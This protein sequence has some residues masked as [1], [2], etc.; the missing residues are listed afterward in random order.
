M[1]NDAGTDANADDAGADG[2]I[3]AVAVTHLCDTQADCLSS[4]DPTAYVC[5]D[6]GEGRRCWPSCH[7]GECGGHV[8]GNV[9]QTSLGLCGCRSAADCSVPALAPFCAPIGV[10]GDCEMEADCSGST[11][12]CDPDFGICVEC[13]LDA[14][15][16]GGACDLNTGNCR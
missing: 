13:F 11:P 15:C 6:R 4:P 7:E 10:C 1:I 2:G 16:P 5:A 14:H 12:H 9:C 8:Q 3:D